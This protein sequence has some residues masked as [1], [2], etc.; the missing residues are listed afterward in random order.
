M[1]AVQIALV[2]R[3]LFAATAAHAASE[4]LYPCDVQQPPGASWT[5]VRQTADMR[6]YQRH[7]AA[8]LPEAAARVQWKATPEDLYR[9]I[10]KYEH[11]AGLIPNVESS[12]VLERNEHHVWVYQRLDYPAPVRDRHYVLE[13]TDRLSH[14][15]TGHY[16]VEWRLSDRYPL[17]GDN[18][19]VPPAAFSG[20]WDI[21]PTP[22]GL[23]AIYR[24]TLDPG[25]L[26]PHWLTHR[27]MRGYLI[28]LMLALKGELDAA[29][30]LKPGDGD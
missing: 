3:L 2:V 15:T 20:C 26:L 4:T 16:R 18:R 29:S 5:P 22:E 17:P 6:L 14:P 9:L 27:A 28:E 12:L 10:W 23:D 11:F 13:S 1:P 7:T 19:A 21:H 30:D 8:G 25:G 24:I